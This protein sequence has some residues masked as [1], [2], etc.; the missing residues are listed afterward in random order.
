MGLMLKKL[1]AF[2]LNAALIIQTGQQHFF[3][4]L[5]RYCVTM[6]IFSK[7]GLILFLSTSQFFLT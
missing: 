2:N 5:N 3:K 1:F 7:T 4:T 6:V